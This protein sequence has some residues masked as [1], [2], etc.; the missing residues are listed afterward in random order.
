MDLDMVYFDG[1]ALFDPSARQTYA[2]FEGLRPDDL[3]LFREA[4]PD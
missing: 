2:R 3:V 4:H 1:R